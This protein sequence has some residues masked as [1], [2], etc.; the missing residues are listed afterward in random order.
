MDADGGASKYPTNKGGAKYGTGYCDA[1]CPHDVKWINGKSNSKDWV[2]IPGDANS[3]T[4]F[5]GSCCDELDIWEANKQS[6]AF[7]TH[8]CTVNEQTECSGV[9][10][11]DNASDNRSV[12]VHHWTRCPLITRLYNKINK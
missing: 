8:P 9:S 2:P 10:C 1:Q 3:G 12:T 5:Y 4:G 11:G 7:T 6:Q